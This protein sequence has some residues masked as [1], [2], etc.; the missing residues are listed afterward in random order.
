MVPW[1]VEMPHRCRLVTAS[2][3]SRF[4]TAVPPLSKRILRDVPQSLRG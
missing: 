4:G 2:W 3:L 1:M